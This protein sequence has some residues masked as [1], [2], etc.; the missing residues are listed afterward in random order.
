VYVV[1]VFVFV[2]VVVMVFVVFVV[3]FSFS[4]LKKGYLQVSAAVLLELTSVIDTQT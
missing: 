2:D 1:F 3:F 4:R